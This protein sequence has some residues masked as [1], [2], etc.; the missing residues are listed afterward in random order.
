MRV[1]VKVGTSSL[2]SERGEIRQDVIAS[3]ATQLSDVKSAGHETLL[4]TSGAITSGELLLNIDRRDA[5]SATLQALSTVGQ[6]RLMSEY[7][8]AFSQRGVLVGQVLVAPS[9]FFDRSRYLLLRGVLERLAELGVVPIIN[10]NDAVANDAI[11]FG[12]N[13]RIAALVAHLV[14]ADKLLLLTDTEGLFTADP[15]I[16]AEASLI[17]EIVE[18]DEQLEAEA[19]GATSSRSK[20]G[21][22]SKL[23]AARISAHSGVEAVIAAT[24]RQDVVRDAV[25]GINVG[26]TFR[27]RS[28]RLSAR[29]LWLGFAAPSQGRLRVDNGAK[30]ALLERGGSLLAV[31]ITD[32]SGNF[33]A[34][35]AVE[36]VGEDGAVFAKG[37]CALSA[38]QVADVAGKRT[39]QIPDSM[40]DEVIHRDQII[41]LPAGMAV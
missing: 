37:L 15:R 2:T 30:S 14:S 38:K 10:E 34:G 41:L 19:S 23:S 33:S 31:G 36:V 26:T 18:L 3:L 5:D 11:G 16:E 20:G 4:V 35:D 7:E 32:A 13:D 21:M 40:P 22:A 6:N 12:D 24:S 27:A 29:K 9:D 17:E 39:G 28:S 25:N 1:V 8:R